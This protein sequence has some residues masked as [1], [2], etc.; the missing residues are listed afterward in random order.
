MLLFGFLLL[1]CAIAL[2]GD[3]EASQ[4]D[5]SGGEYFQCT[6]QLIYYRTGP[7]GEYYRLFNV[8]YMPDKLFYMENISGP[9]KS[10]AVDASKEITLTKYKAR[11]NRLYVKPPG[12][13]DPLPIT[14]QRMKIN[15]LIKSFIKESYGVEFEKISSYGCANAA[16]EDSDTQWPSQTKLSQRY[17]ICNDGHPYHQVDR[18]HYYK[19]HLFVPDIESQEIV[20]DYFFYK[21]KSDRPENDIAVQ[22]RRWFIL[23]Y[24][25]NVPTI[26]SMDNLSPNFIS[27]DQCAEKHISTYAKMADERMPLM[28]KLNALMT[29]MWNGI[30]LDGNH[31]QTT[32]DPS[33]PQNYESKLFQAH[34][35]YKNTIKSKTRK[36]WITWMIEKYTGTKENKKD[37]EI[38]NIVEC[39]WASHCI[40]IVLGL[41]SKL[42]YQLNEQGLLDDHVIQKLYAISSAKTPYTELKPLAQKLEKIAD[43]LKAKFEEIMK[44]RRDNSENE[45]HLPISD[46]PIPNLDNI[47]L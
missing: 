17:I 31:V 15:V 27:L 14:R 40:S 47:T 19:L 35:N 34:D 46:L 30:S 44:I 25:L 43:E 3:I 37:L 28:H 22:R 38:E 24:S 29:T 4:T 32:Y 2:A 13:V 21:L 42:K 23:D 10:I 16:I 26:K 12:A 9:I 45:S 7:A 41:Y 33:K 6:N 18:Q 1:L 11:T 20:S 8:H 36:D 39:F 5:I